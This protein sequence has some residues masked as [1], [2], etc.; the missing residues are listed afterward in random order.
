MAKKAT[1]T[2]LEQELAKLDKPATEQR[3]KFEHERQAAQERLADTQSA[4]VEAAAKIEELEA[5]LSEL[6]GPAL[7][8]NEGSERELVRLVEEI[9]GRKRRWRLAEIAVQRCERQMIE[10]E[11]RQRE[12]ER[13]LLEKRY[14]LLAHAKKA[15]SEKVEALV[16]ELSAELEGLLEVANAQIPVAQSLGLRDGRAYSDILEQRLGTVL[17]D[18][19]PNNGRPLARLDEPLSALDPHTKPLAEQRVAHTESVRRNQELQAQ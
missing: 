13:D 11:E 3:E 5:R 15:R 8:G 7:E 19:V 1:T 10:L 4:V 18:Y 17:G 9:D 12:T 2:S 14:D 16:E 6:A